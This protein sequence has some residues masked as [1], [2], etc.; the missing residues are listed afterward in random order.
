VTNYS[1]TG[2]N[3]DVIVFDN[4]VFVLN[5]LLTGL[6]IPPTEVRI[7]ESARA[8]GIHRNTKRGVRNIDLPV[9][10]LGSSP[11]VVEQ[12]LRRLA[13]LTQDDR[14]PTRL[15]AI[16]PAGNLVMELHYTGGAELQYGKDDAGKTWAKTLLSFQAPQPFWQSAIQQ[17]FTITAGQTGRGLLPK[18]TKLR[19]SSAT[20]LGIVAVNNTGDVPVFPVYTV[21]GPI[22]NFFVRGGR[23]SFGFNAAVND[24]ET[25]T[26]NTEKGTVVADNGANRYSLLLPFPKFFPLGTGESTLEIQGDNTSLSTFVGV[27]YNQRFEV[28]HG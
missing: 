9:T 2:A 1:L 14:G 27:S 25:I 23:L 28:V 22:D 7:D 26:V 3:G 11:T 4:S 10:V 13:R 24:G 15:T 12:N 20:T 16:R 5:P 8:G 18:L 19:V 17:S 6:G 21:R